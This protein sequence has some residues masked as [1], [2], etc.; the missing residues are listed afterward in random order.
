MVSAGAKGIILESYG[1]GNFPSGNP[2]SPKDGAIARS[3][4]AATDA[5]IVVVGATQVEAGTVNA[6]AYASEAWL[7]WA[8]AIGVGDMTAIAAF[9]KTMVLLAE[10]GW[11]GNDWDAHTVR[12]LVG[13]S[14]A[15]ECTVT[16]R[17]GALGRTPLL[18]GESLKVMDGSAAL[19]NFA[20]RGPVLVGADGKTLWEALERVP[21][22]L[23]GNLVADGGSVRLIGRDG[24]SCG[25][26]PREQPPQVCHSEGPA[27]LE[28][29]N[30]WSQLRTAGS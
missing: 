19:T 26:W 1:E 17:V 11:E 5:G 3:I 13:Q 28:T 2:D 21:E 8:G 10:Q 9:A 6:L 14:F 7:P 25:M 15:G 20:E 24:G 18:P 29:L 22:S 16:D 23:P 12:D 30:C 27:P 4:K